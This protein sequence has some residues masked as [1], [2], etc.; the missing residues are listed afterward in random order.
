MLSGGDELTLYWMDSNNTRTALVSVDANLTTGTWY[1]VEVAAKP[2]TDYREIWV[3]GVSKGSTTASTIS[4]FAVPVG[5]MY[6]GD[7]VVG[8]SVDVH[9]DNIIISTDS[10]DSF[11]DCKDELEWPE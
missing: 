3:D 7:F 10:I 6:M 11:T 5:T 2:S 9:M 1:W 4:S 8:A